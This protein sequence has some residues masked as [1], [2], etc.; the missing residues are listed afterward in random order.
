[1]QTK[2]VKIPN[3][4]LSTACWEGEIEDQGSDAKNLGEAVKAAIKAGAYLSGAYLS[5]ANLSGANLS[6]AN[7][8]GA[9][10]SGANLSGAYL[11]RANLDGADLSRAYLSGANLSGANLSGANL[12]GAY[13]SGA[14]LSRAYLD[15][16]NLSGA[17]LSGANLSGAYLDGAYLD[18]E[19]RLLPNGIRMIGPIGSRASYCTAYATDKGLR[20]RAWCF[21]GS[22]KEFLAKIKESH[23]GNEHAKDY[24]AWIRMC[25]E[26][27]KRIAGEQ[28]RGLRA[29]KA[30]NHTKRKG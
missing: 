13:L 29:M 23:G 30:D 8:S 15:G 27:Y 4:W 11:S 18:G 5:G 14:Y 3:R 16:A 6:G 17:N 24:R 2:T 9:Y 25:R 7:L 21:F 22:E 19:E 12:S 26:W 1:M 10:L 20:F 28:A